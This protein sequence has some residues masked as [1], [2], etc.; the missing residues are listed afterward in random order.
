VAV[1]PGQHH[2]RATHFV[3]MDFA[4]PDVS[5]EAIAAGLAARVEKISEL[6]G[7]RDMLER[8]L[9]YAGPSFLRRQ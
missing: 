9:A 2:N 4:D 3:G 8:A 1:T 6:G 7:V 5:T